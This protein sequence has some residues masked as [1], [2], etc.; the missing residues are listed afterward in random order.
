MITSFTIPV[1]FFANFREIIGLKETTVTLS[2]NQTVLDLL[3]ILRKT[4]PNG[5]EFYEN[6]VD[7]P[8]HT[9]QPY[10]KIIIDGKILFNKQALDTVISPDVGIILIFPPVGGG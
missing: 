8:G 3:Q 1:Q 2:E 9:L 5:K 10:V 7:E 6:V 4:V